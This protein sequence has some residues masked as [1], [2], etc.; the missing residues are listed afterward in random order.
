MSDI[1]GRTAVITGGYGVLCSVIAK[2]MAAE[3]TNIAVLGR[4]KEKADEVALEINRQGGKALG[5]GTGA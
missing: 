5:V 3:G 1:Q 4:R 2:A